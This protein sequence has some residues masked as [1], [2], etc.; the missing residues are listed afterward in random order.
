MTLEPLLSAPAVVQ[1]HA[2]A[3]MGAFAL[4]IAQMIG[5]KGVTLHRILG[6]SWVVLMLMVSVSSFWIASRGHW[7]WIHLLSVTVLVM[8]PIGIYAARRGSV[9]RHSRV[10]ASVFF[11]G[12]VVAGLFTFIPGRIM[13]SVVF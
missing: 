4:G 8:L 10:M 5:R 2:F 7:S 3:A 11:L 12:L 9:R 6:W 1:V 13:N